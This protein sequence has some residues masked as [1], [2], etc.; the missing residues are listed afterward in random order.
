MIIDTNTDRELKKKQEEEE[1]A[2]VYDSFVGERNRQTDRQ[3]H[4]YTEA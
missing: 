1:A 4:I 3:R 2:K